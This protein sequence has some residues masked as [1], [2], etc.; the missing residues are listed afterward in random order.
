MYTFSELAVYLGVHEQ[1]LEKHQRRGTLVADV[2]MQNGDRLY[3]DETV[4]AFEANY[5]SSLCKLD[6]ISQIVGVKLNRVKYIFLRRLQLKPDAM[7]GQAFCY[8]AANILSVAQNQQW[9]K[10]V[11]KNRL[12]AHTFYVIDRMSDGKMILLAEEERRLESL[13]E[14]EGTVSEI[15]AGVIGEYT[16][17]KAKSPPADLLP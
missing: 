17:Q 4:D 6:E 2:Q 9:L 11:A 3:R 5:F 13:G 14:R 16:R 1:T 15:L 7:V 12:G 10:V 8:T